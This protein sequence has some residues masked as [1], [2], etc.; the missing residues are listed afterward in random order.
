MSSA[1]QVPSDAIVILSTGDGGAPLSR[2]A[3]EELQRM[4]QEQGCSQERVLIDLLT[5]PEE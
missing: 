5:E 1:N 4:A 3:W 2:E